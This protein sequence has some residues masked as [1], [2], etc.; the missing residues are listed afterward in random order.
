MI[1][2]QFKKC[3]LQLIVKLIIDLLDKH[4]GNKDLVVIFVYYIASVPKNRQDRSKPTTTYW[5]RTAVYAQGFVVSLLTAAATFQA[6]KGTSEPRNIHGYGLNSIGSCKI[7]TELSQVDQ[8]GLVYGLFIDGKRC[9]NGVFTTMDVDIQDAFEIS[10]RNRQLYLIKRK[11]KCQQSRLHHQDSEL[12]SSQSAL[13]SFSSSL[14]TNNQSIS[15]PLITIDTSND[16]D[17]VIYN[18]INE[19]S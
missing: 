13:L 4:G 2:E 18:N 7:K 17:N 3:F 1:Y 6:V 10:N 11:E 19:Y 5:I 12:I 15:L 16:E 8:N 9:Q 14:E